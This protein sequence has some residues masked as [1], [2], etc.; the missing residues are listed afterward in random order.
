MTK[1]T[2]SKYEMT[3]GLDVAEIAKLVRKD[4]KKAGYRAS[5]RISRYSMGRSIQVEVKDL[6][7]GTN[8]AEA[9]EWVAYPGAADGE[10]ESPA[11]IGNKGWFRPVALTAVENIVKAYQIAENDLQTDYFWSNFHI[12]TDMAETLRETCTEAHIAKLSA[13]AEPQK[14][15]QVEMLETLGLL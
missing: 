4:L 12:S 5:V 6:P 10:Y 3:K 9:V 7:K 1:H 14:S 2:G 8:L 13:P 15:S 11:D